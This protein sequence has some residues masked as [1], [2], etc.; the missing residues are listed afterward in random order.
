MTL[1]FSG[2]TSG[3][4]LSFGVDRDFAN[5]NGNPTEFGGN[6]GDEVGGAK[7]TATLSPK[8]DRDKD[9]DTLIG[10]FRNDLDFGYQIYDGFGLID[11][12]NALRLTRPHD[13]D[14]Q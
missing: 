9:A 3:Q 8:G 11:A 5:V 13:N 7:V 10:V 6:S 14:D 2:F 1:T 12:V 4:S